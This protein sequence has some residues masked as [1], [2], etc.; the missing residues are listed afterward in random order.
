M[1]ARKN[2]CGVDPEKSPAVSGVVSD[3]LVEQGG[4]VS[5]AVNS[6]PSLL[7]REEDEDSVLADDPFEEL[8]DRPRY[9]CV[10]HDSA[11]K[12][13]SPYNEGWEWQK[14]VCAMDNSKQ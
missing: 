14:Q 5:A 4:H 6:R 7:A 8:E 3:D 10:V 2:V 13:P 1:A 9:R 12:V 11:L